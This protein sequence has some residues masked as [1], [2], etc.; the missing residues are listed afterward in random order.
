MT[1]NTDAAV[2]AENAKKVFKRTLGYDLARAIVC[3]VYNGQYPQ[4]IPLHFK[5]RK[6]TYTHSLTCKHIKK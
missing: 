4:Y 1:E 3:G 2:G 6:H 5:S